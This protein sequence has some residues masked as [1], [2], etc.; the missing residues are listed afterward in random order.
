MYHLGKRV[1]PS[2]RSVASSEKLWETVSAPSFGVHHKTE[3]IGND[4][5]YTHCTSIRRVS[6]QV[7]F[8]SSLNN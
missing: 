2:E 7:N 6:Y 3:Y 8:R 5:V 1:Y 4:I